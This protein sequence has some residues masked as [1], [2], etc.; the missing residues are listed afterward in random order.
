MQSWSLNTK[1][2]IEPQDLEVMDRLLFRAH[3]LS[4]RVQKQT[5]EFAVKRGKEIQKVLSGNVWEA[6][7]PKKSK[8]KAGIGTGKKSSGKKKPV[9][10]PGAT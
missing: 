4:Q 8:K 3:E 2:V 5:D 10:P 9:A 7:K 1:P 6:E